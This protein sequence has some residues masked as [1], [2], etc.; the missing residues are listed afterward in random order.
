MTTTLRPDGPE[1]RRPDG[2]RAR[3]FTVCVN[4]R[5]VGAVELSTGDTLGPTVGT[6]AGLAVDEADRGRG[7]GAVASL[8]A[9]EVLRS[10]GC[11]RVRIAVPADAA[12]ALRLAASLGYTERSRHLRKDVGPAGPLPPGT[13]VRPLSV[14]DYGPWLARGREQFVESLTELGIPRAEAEE[15]EAASARS[16]LPGTHPKA[17]GAADGVVLLGVA[18]DGA[19][20]AALWLRTGDP[21]WV[22]AVEVAEAVRGRGH[23]RTAMLVAEDAC[24][25]ARARTIG[26]NVFV[27]NEPAVRLYA[28]LGYRPT[29]R[30]FVKPLL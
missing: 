20:V 9:E 11:A 28:S 18:H 27:A 30:H 2:F 14:A 21:A 25:A 7:R 6:I 1:R 16:L 15:R 8:A 29:V 22:Y 26:L 23:G 5:P 4:G 24:R 17:P 3:A 13:T 10:W 19:D 12:Y